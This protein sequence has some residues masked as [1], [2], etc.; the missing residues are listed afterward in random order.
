MGKLDDLKVGDAVC[1]A[2]SGGWDRRILRL[3]RGTVEKVTK[4]QVTALG[5]RWLKSTGCR[6]GSGGGWSQEYLQRLTPEIEAEFE[7]DQLMFQA[8]RDCKKASDLLS[9]QRGENAINLHHLA[10]AVI[11]AME[12]DG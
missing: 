9:R 2:E 12:A 6:V 11:A 3:N 7:I 10:K 4:T 5:D 1:V 8:E